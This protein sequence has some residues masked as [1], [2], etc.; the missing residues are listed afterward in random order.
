[1]VLRIL[2]GV[3]WL[4]IAFLVLIGVVLAEAHFEIRRVTPPLPDAAAL[5]ER[6]REAVGPIRLSYINTASQPGRGPFTIG[7]PAFLLEW[8]DG[9][10]FLIDTGMDRE[11]AEAFGRLAER[12]FGSGPIQAH[13]S[14]VEQLGD[15]IARISGV[16]FTHLHA[17][18]TN[19]LLS[20]CAAGAGPL[21][22]FQTHNHYTSLNS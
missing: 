21:D 1:M 18:H 12:V 20:L 7:H 13:G 17:D 6:V 10:G 5:Q 14:L 4:V 16:A 19:G 8:A 2:K 9:R 15:R 11:A 22:L 3:G